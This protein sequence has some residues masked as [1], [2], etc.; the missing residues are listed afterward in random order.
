VSKV[1]EVY[2][3]LSYLAGITILDLIPSDR[4]EQEILFQLYEI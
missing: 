3:S 2:K 4:L 1:N